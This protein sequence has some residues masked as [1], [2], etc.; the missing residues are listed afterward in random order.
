MVLRLKYERTHARTHLAGWRAA[1]HPVPL[2]IFFCTSLNVRQPANRARFFLHCLVCGNGPLLDPKLNAYWKKS[3]PSLVLNVDRHSSAMEAGLGDLWEDT[4]ASFFTLCLQGAVERGAG[5]YSPAVTSAIFSRRC[6]FCTS[7]CPAGM[8]LDLAP[9]LRSP[10]SVLV[11]FRMP[12]TCTAAFGL[13]SSVGLDCELERCTSLGL[14]L[15]EPA[16][17]RS[18]GRCREGSRTGPFCT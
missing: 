5:E 13:R 2:L 1:H 9:P 14:R 11:F 16:C 4:V 17:C 18:E 3:Y 6:P 10:S 12:L 15:S 7:V 8:L